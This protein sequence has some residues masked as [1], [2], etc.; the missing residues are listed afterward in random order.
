MITQRVGHPS[1]SYAI[2]MNHKTI[3]IINIHGLTWRLIQLSLAKIKNQ[4]TYRFVRYNFSAQTPIVA[5]LTY[6]S[7]VQ[8][9]FPLRQ[10]PGTIPAMKVHLDHLP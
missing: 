2:W 10:E 6:L 9:F 3:P 8:Q 5:L 7:T 1:H 4:E